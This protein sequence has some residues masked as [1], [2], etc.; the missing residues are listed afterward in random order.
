MVKL[1][2]STMEIYQ[3]LCLRRRRRRSLSMYEKATKEEEENNHCNNN[4]NNN[5]LFELRQCFE[6]KCKKLCKIGTM[7]LYDNI[8]AG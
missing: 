7:T 3:R 4:N 2:K 8:Y 5:N 1:V 6:N